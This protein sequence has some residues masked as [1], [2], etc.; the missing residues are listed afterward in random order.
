[1]DFLKDEIERKRKE[2]SAIQGGAAKLRKYMR[3]GDVE[4]QQQQQQKLAVPDSTPPPA[5]SAPSS[6]SSSPPPQQQ[7]QQP[8]SRDVQ[9]EQ[10][11]PVTDSNRLLDSAPRIPEAELVARLRAKGVPVRLFAEEY[12]QRVARLKALESA[13][14][15]SD[16]QRNDFRQLLAKEADRLAQDYLERKA[17]IDGLENATLTQKQNLEAALE[18]IDTRQIG[19]KLMEADPEKNRYLIGAYFKKLLLVWERTLNDRDDVEKGSTKGRLATVTR[20]QTSEYLKPFF[21]QLKRGTLEADVIARVTEICMHMQERE[22]LKANDAY[23]RLSI[24]NAPWP[25]GVTMVGIHERS[26]REKISSS[27]VAHGLNDETQR[28]WIQSIKRLITFAQSVWPPDDLGKAI[29]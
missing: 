14:E 4:A 6:S 7:Q 18:K 9:N 5:A 8:S 29:G 27:Q 16:G 21:I 17:G 13:E 11:A 12:H 24:G 2:V 1:M 3:R 23:L 22:Y 10:P 15:R 25:I 20:A 28:K 26:G 19:K